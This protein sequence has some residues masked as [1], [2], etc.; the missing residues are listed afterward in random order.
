MIWA[1]DGGHVGL[2]SSRHENV[3]RQIRTVVSLA[4]FWGRCHGRIS[5]NKQ[6]VGTVVSR[7]ERRAIYVR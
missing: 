4:M 7:L 5:D 3:I 2:F 6:Y 1:I